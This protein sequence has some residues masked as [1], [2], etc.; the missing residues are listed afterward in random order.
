MMWSL[1]TPVIALIAVY[2]IGILLG[3]PIPF[4]AE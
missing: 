2:Q 1:I 3:S 4:Y